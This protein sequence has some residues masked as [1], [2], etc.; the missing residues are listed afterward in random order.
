M[1]GYATEGFQR[2]G[3]KEITENWVCSVCLRNILLSL[4]FSHVENGGLFIYN[5][6]PT[7]GRSL[8]SKASAHYESYILDISFPIKHVLNMF[9]NP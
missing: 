1:A 4:S 6:A 9:V 5:V 3:T 8:G 7:K 2:Q